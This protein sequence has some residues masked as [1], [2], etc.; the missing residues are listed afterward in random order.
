MI[1]SK[2]KDGEAIINLV[3]STLGDSYAASTALNIFFDDIVKA[4]RAL[5]LATAGQFVQRVT[6][7]DGGTII[8]GEGM[9]TSIR[10]VV[11]VIEG[12]APLAALTLTLPN[13]TFDRSGQFI[14]VVTMIDITA[15]SFSPPATVF[16]PPTTM[17]TND[18]FGLNNVGLL[19]WI[20]VA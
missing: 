8:V 6:P 7:A 2:P 14:R 11:L 10:P 15:L 12:A 16:N 19:E 13:G 5:E 1:N 4:L 17:F 20:R 18:A 3:K 9:G